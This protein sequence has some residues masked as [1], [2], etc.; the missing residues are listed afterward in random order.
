MARIICLAIGYLCGL[1]QTGYFYSKKKDFDLRANGSG[2]SGTTN[3]I[4]TMGWKAGGIVFLGDVL[5]CFLAVFLVWLIYHKVETVDVKLLQIYGAA[6][7]ILGHDFPF[8]LNFKGG[9]GMACTAGMIGCA[10][11]M[12]IPVELAVFLIPVFITRYVSLGSILV[13]IGLPIFAWLFHSAGW[14]YVGGSHVM[15]FFLLLCAIGALN[16]FSHRSN[17]VRLIYGNENKIG[18]KKK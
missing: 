6:G 7:C 10:L 3:T 14:L 4:R 18:V 2:N 5:K 16:V 15:E 12:M 13:S 9:K 8:Y 17:I 11:P 1:F